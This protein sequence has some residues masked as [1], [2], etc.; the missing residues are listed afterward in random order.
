MNVDSYQKQYDEATR[1]YEEIPD[2]AGDSVMK[3]KWM[4]GVSLCAVLGIAYGVSV[5]TMHSTPEKNVNKV[6]AESDYSNNNTYPYVKVAMIG[7]SMMYFNDLPRFMGASKSRNTVRKL[8]TTLQGY[9]LS[10]THSYT[11]AC[12]LQKRSRMVTYRKFRACT[13]TQISRQYFKRGSVCTIAFGTVA[14]MDCTANFHSNCSL[15]CILC[16]MACSVSGTRLQL[17]LEYRVQ[18]TFGNIYV[19]SDDGDAE[20]VDDKLA[21][22]DAVDYDF[23]EEDGEDFVSFNDGT[24]P[25][26][27]NP[28][29][30][31]Y[32]VSKVYSD[33]KNHKWDYILINDSTHSPAR[34]ESRQQMLEILQET[35]VPWFIQT[36]ATPVFLATYAY[37][38]PHRHIL[39]NIPEFT[40]LTMAGYQAYV[41]MLSEQLPALQQPRIA[42]VGLAFLMVWEENRSLWER[43]FHVDQIHCSPLGTYLQGLVVHHT[44]FGIMPQS[45]IAVQDDMPLLWHLARFFQPVEEQP[46][47][48]PTKEEAAYLYQIAVRV[49]IDKEVPRSVIEYTNG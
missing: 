34:A 4:V 38:R 32:L 45:T 37:E 7:N 33:N 11:F 14:T 3:K 39:E 8:E 10:L 48:F 47:P 2:G 49:T 36:G 5:S 46:N 27:R 18:E 44:I 12:I 17:A 35:Y 20:V 26:L 40:S 25:C 15:S 13:R 6:F 41:D 9:F 42:P 16:R 29:Y 19:E 30:Y 22:D 43:L 28:L 1:M 21:S 23:Q 24:N 31:K